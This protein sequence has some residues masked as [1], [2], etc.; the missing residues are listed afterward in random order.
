MQINAGNSLIKTQDFI[1]KEF[2]QSLHFSHTASI[3]CMK[4]P[5]DLHTQKPFI[6]LYLVSHKV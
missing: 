4:G 2:G 3:T 5:L 1:S 6:H